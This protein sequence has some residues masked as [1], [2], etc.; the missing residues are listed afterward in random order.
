[1]TTCNI[2]INTFIWHYSPRPWGR[3]MV[4]ELKSFRP[5]LYL[6]SFGGPMLS[7][8]SEI[9][10]RSSRSQMWEKGM[11]IMLK[12]ETPADCRSIENGKLI[13][14][15]ERHS[16]NFS[17]Y[18]LA[19]SSPSKMAHRRMLRVSLPHRRQRSTKA[20]AA[21]TDFSPISN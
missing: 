17:A 10:T 8:K 3:A 1:M 11:R 2:K 21:S 4:W 13:T 18:F 6:Q 20:I 5:I 7:R 19:R 12:Q 14:C 16:E 15:K 9:N